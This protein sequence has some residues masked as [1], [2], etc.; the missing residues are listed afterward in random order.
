NFLRHQHFAVSCVFIVKSRWR[1]VQGVEKTIFPARRF[2]AAPGAV[3]GAGRSSPLSKPSPPLSVAP[4]SSHSYGNI[5]EKET[6]TFLANSIEKENVFLMDSR[7]S[8]MV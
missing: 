7:R 3:P 6:N 8:K 5:T 1:N 2:I 4:S